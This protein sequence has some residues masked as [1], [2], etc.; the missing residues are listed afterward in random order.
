A[1][2]RSLAR[3]R[4]RA[5][6]KREATAAAAAAEKRALEQAQAAARLEELRQQW[7][8]WRATKIP[9]EPST[10]VRLAL[11]MPPSAGG[12][13][14]IRRFPSEASLEDLYAFVEC[15][16]LLQEPESLE[17]DAAKP[18]DYEHKYLFRIA[19]M[20]PRETLEPSHS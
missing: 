13:R 2:G 3:A 11:N 20:M 9:A 15:Y 1:Y 10:G 6:Q 12:G 4:E 19:S 8:R 17:G 18:R 14:V 16:S 5:R 7:R